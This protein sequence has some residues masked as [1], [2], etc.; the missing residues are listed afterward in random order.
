MQEKFCQSCG[1]PMENDELYG[2]EANGSKSVDY[3]KYCYESGAFTE[4]DCTLEEMIESVAAIMVTDFGFSADDANAQCNEGIPT[5]K[6]WK[7]A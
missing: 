4:P 1:M 3:C 5:L 7:K 2:T 6:R